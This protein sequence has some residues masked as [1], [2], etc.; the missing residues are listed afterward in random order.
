MGK[1]TY[2]LYLVTLSVILI[3]GVIILSDMDM[4]FSLSIA[5]AL[6]KSISFLGA[7]FLSE[8]LIDGDLS[9]PN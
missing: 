1:S 8:L 2:E 4:D 6:D 3:Y 9:A 5:V 7:F